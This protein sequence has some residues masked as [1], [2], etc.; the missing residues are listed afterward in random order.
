MSDP[1]VGE[2]GSFAGCWVCRSAM[3]WGVADDEGDIFRFLFE[4]D[5]ECSSL[6]LFRGEGDA[7]DPALREGFVFE[8][9]DAPCVLIREW[10]A[11]IAHMYS[12]MLMPNPLKSM[13]FTFRCFQTG[14]W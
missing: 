1:V 9:D 5:F 10:S 12:P 13:G 8:D 4:S 3:R 2:E 6:N 14:A 11:A 7:L